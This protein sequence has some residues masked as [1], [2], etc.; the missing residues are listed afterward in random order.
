MKEKNSIKVT[1]AGRTY[2]I[3]SDEDEKEQVQEAAM[4]VNSLL[5]EYEEEYVVRD[6]QD[7]LAMCALNLA[8]ASLKPTEGSE[9]DQVNGAVSEQLVDI[10][11]FISK[12]LRKVN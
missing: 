11:S 9:T 3:S 8:S 7:L 6:K 4:L 12:Y 5:K 10:E 1:I 2:P